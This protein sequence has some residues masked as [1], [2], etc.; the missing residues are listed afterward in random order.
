[1]SLPAPCYSTGRSPTKW[2]HPAL[3]AQYSQARHVSTEWGLYPAARAMNKTFVIR[4][5]T[6]VADR[7]TVQ[8]EFHNVGALDQFRTARPR[9]QVVLGI[10]GMAHADVAIGIDDAFVGQDAVGDDDLADVEV[11][12]AH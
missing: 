5:A 4:C 3:L 7:L 1:M 9:Q 8:G 6:V 12:V 2:P 11:Q 10:G